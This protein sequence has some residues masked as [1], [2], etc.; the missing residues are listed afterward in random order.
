MV[1]TVDY[2][3]IRAISSGLETSDGA[4]VCANPCWY[5]GAI[6]ASGTGL[7]LDTKLTVYDNATEADGTEVD[8]LQCVNSDGQDPEIMLTACNILEE[9]VWCA[10]G[11]YAEP[12]EQYSSWLVWFSR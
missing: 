10:N 3:H 6:L 9:P 5:L 11:I 4:V 2:D 7:D 1:R 8:Y 12:S